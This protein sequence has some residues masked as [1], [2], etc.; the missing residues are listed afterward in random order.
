M[1]ARLVGAARVPGRLVLPG[2]FGRADTVSARV[3]RIWRRPFFIS[4]VCFSHACSFF[5][6]SL[7]VCCSLSGT[8]V[9]AVRAHTQRC[10]T[11]ATTARS[12]RRHKARVRCA[13]ARRAC[14]VRKGTRRARPSGASRATCARRLARRSG[15]IAPPGAAMNHVYN[16]RFFSHTLLTFLN[17]PFHTGS[18]APPLG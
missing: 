7:S 9:R 4:V 6:F 1:S 12:T 11:P 18:T 8:C 15:R 2:E 3:R 5:C 14:T 13:S 17:N 10:A 16:G